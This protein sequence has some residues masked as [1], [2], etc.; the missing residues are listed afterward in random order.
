MTYRY[1]SDVVW[2]SMDERVL[3]TTVEPQEVLVLVD[4]AALIW[5]SLPG[6]DHQQLVE[7]VAEAAGVAPES[8]SGDVTAFVAQLRERGLVVEDAS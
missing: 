8:I 3:V 4:S 1:A 6:S 2:E 5:L 7:T